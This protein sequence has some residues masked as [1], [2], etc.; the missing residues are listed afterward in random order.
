MLT[1]IKKK[2]DICTGYQCEG[3][4]DFFNGNHMR[5][6]D[7]L[8]SD[9]IEPWKHNPEIEY[10]H[11]CP[12]RRDVRESHINMWD[13]PNGTYRKQ[14]WGE[15]QI[16]KLAKL[17]DKMDKDDLKLFVAL[18]KERPMD[19]FFDYDV[20]ADISGLDA[21]DMRDG[22]VEIV[23]EKRIIVPLFFLNFMKLNLTNHYFIIRTFQ[24]LECC[25][26]AE[27]V[28]E[29]SNIKEFNSVIEF[30]DSFYDIL[31]SA[32]NEVSD[33]DALRDKLNE[34]SEIEEIKEADVDRQFRRWVCRLDEETGFWEECVFTD[35]FLEDRTVKKTIEENEFTK[36]GK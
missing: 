9:V 21:K 25:R 27:I 2:D 24:N 30:S 8:L 1:G 20:L 35:D 16:E 19:Q 33:I 26:K 13:A 32:Y 23:E 3:D 5:V 22:I 34:F 15:G 10:V 12:V 11:L 7:N 36:E 4:F 28:D 18:N 29:I 6:L 17:Q 14:F 31:V